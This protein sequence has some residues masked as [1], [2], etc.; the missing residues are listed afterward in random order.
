MLAPPP[1]PAAHTLSNAAANKGVAKITFDVEV[2]GTRSDSRTTMRMQW[3][4]DRVRSENNQWTTALT[5]PDEPGLE[6]AP[7]ADLRPTSAVVD[8]T[9][10]VT[11]LQ[12]NGEVFKPR[13]YAEIVSAGYKLQTPPS[14][15]EAA[16]AVEL[17]RK[18]VERFG[19]VGLQIQW[20][21]ALVRSPAERHADVVRAVRAFDAPAIDDRGYAH[22]TRVQGDTKIDIEID[23]A[24]DDVLSLSST[25]DGELATRVAHRFVDGPDGWSV[26]RVSVAESSAL[27]GQPART[28][29]VTLS[30]VVINGRSIP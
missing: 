27:R 25:L 14:A 23:P 2:V 13:T 19:S 10:H 20:I 29:T 5:L 17:E 12:K 24:T 30:N 15:E 6:S 28:S 26:R 9:G 16:R 21:E 1:A 7:G 3:H 18:L 4:V 8:A 22:Y 11:I